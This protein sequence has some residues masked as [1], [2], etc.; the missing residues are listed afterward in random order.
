MEHSLLA[1]LAKQPTEKLEGA[2][3]YY[4]KSDRLYSNRFAV[5]EILQELGRRREPITEDLPPHIR[6]AWEKY[7]RCV[8]EADTASE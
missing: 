3:V 5:V 8:A 1:Y 4:L 2:L 7:L 6:Q